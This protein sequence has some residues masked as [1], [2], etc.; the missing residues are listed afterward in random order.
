MN[1]NQT[2]KMLIE[3]DKL[4]NKLFNFQNDKIL[5]KQYC[6]LNNEGHKLVTE[7]TSRCNTKLVTER[8]SRCNSSF[9]SEVYLC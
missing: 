2:E 7:R 9:D 3:I 6:V 5:A 1:S 8:T 4:I